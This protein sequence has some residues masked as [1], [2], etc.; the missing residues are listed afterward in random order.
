[1]RS[2]ILGWR[3]LSRQ[4]RRSLAGALLC[5]LV[6]LVMAWAARPAVAEEHV[7]RIG[8]QK[9]GTLVILREQ[10]ALE[11]VL[12]KLGWL[13]RWTEFPAGPQL[14]EALN[15]GELDFGTTGEAPP[16]FAQAAGAPLVYVGAEPPSPAGEAILVPEASTIHS[17]ADLK[18]RRI[19]LNKGSNVHF[20]LV[21]ALASAQLKPEDIEPVYLA[22]A[23]ARAAF[24]QGAV[25]AWAIWDPFFAAG[26]A[27]THARVLVDA[28]GLAPN[29][30][31]FL[32]TRDFAQT[33]P[34]LLRTLLDQIAVTDHWA[35]THQ[36]DVAAILAP[37]LKLP[38]PVIE[39]ALGRMGYGVGPITAEVADDQQRI[40][41]AFHALRLIPVAVNIRDALWSPPS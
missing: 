32:A 33:Q 27:A 5:G 37:T 3:D 19:A 11:P 8:V 1:M 23:D 39:T 20:L 34:T 30:Q 16:V 35:E 12:R 40:A 31:F 4:S 6:M 36:A 22:P 10:H 24:E 25:D 7:L 13:V 26:Q 9:Y 41:D 15:V 17:V 2:L 28:K 38:V 29:R 21:Q 18:G 14:L